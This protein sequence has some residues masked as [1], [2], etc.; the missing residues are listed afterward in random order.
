VKILLYSLPLIAAITG[1]VTNYIAVKMLFHPRKPINLGLFS[2][3]G[4][5]PKRHQKLAQQL[6]ELVGRE[7]LSTDDLKGLLSN[8]EMFDGAEQLIGAKID[9]FIN[10]FL[11]SKPMLSMFISSDF[12]TQIKEAILLEIRNAMPELME[13]FM[14]KMEQKIDVKQVVADKISKFSTNKLEDMLY[15][16]MAKEFHFI[17]I[18]GGVLGFI[19]GLIQLGI[20]L[21]QD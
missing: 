13:L 2:I 4:I 9:G 21:M 16:I 7:L 12:K 8:P 11:D 5:F 19:I 18:L 1:W 15:S 20:V 6:G 3:Q 10:N 14:Q 17:E